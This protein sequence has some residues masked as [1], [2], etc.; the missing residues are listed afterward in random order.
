MKSLT[1][2]IFSASSTGTSAHV[3]IRQGDVNLPATAQILSLVDFHITLRIF[4][5][6]YGRG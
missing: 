4:V 6:G 3:K 2:G 5:Y 1:A